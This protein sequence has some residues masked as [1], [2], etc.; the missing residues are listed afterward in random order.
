[1]I[2]WMKIRFVVIFG[3]VI[4]IFLFL[5][6]F[7]LQNTFVLFGDSARDL[8]E[9]HEWQQTALPP[10]LGPHTSAISFNQ[11]AWYFYWLMPF[12]LLSN[13]SIY[14]ANIGIIVYYCAW[15]GL[16]VWSVKKHWL[17]SWELVLLSAL[18]SF[19]PELVKQ[20]RNVWNPSMVFPPVL[21]VSL[22]AVSLNWKQIGKKTLAFMAFCLILAVS[23]S[24]SIV[25]FAFVV[26]LYVIF[27][28]W[29][30]SKNWVHQSGHLL[31][32]IFISV[33]VLNIG[34]IAYELKYQ[35]QLTKNLGNQQV[36]QVATDQSLKWQQLMESTLKSEW[37]WLVL[38]VTTSASHL[39]LNRKVS[40]QKELRTSLSLL[41][42]IMGATL[43][44][45]FA[46]HDHYIFGILAMFF[47]VS[48]KVPKTA[49][50]FMMTAC[51]VTWIHW[52]WQSTVFEPV[53]P[54]TSGK[55]NCLKRVCEQFP[56]PI[57]LVGNAQSHDHQALEYSYLAKT[58]NCDGFAITEITSQQPRSMAMFNQNSNFELGKTDFY[59]FNRFPNKQYEDAIDCTPELSVSFFSY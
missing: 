5:R 9:L 54:T 33:L 2:V 44:S 36:L 6:L 56:S 10:L 8:L 59:E 30:H 57:F 19:H 51:I 26:I 41:L 47:V 14:T 40:I 38:V 50:V 15:F 28:L 1:M 55:L 18:I 58:I 46:I 34:T 52:L 24:Y 31:L 13:N 27:Q 23:M 37:L 20:L 11:S 17:K 42:L 25:P 12:Y 48:I 35:F 21:A 29:Q 7:N 16:G 49:R 4:S 3:I 39:L 45:P 22:M 43:V 32:Y 53:A